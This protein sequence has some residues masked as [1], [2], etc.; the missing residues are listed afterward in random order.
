MFVGVGAE[1]VV[2]VFVGVEVGRGLVLF[3]RHRVWD[4]KGTMH[5]DHIKK[6]K[7]SYKRA[8]LSLSC[9]NLS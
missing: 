1:V 4:Y 2:V 3:G 8:S 9:L 5:G 7:F 6:N